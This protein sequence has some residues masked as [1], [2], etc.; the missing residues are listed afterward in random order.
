MSVTD[1]L[2][3]VEAV[4]SGRPVYVESAARRDERFPELGPLGAVA[5]ASL[6][7][8]VDGNVVGGLGLSFD[9]VQP[10]SPAD[11]VALERVAASC[12]RTIDRL[13]V[14]AV[15]SHAGELLANLVDVSSIG[16]I[17]G[18]DDRILEAND[19]FLAMLGYRHTDLEAGE[20][21]WPE[22]TPDEWNSVDDEIVDQ[23]MS[24][25]TSR[26]DGQGVR[27]PPRPPGPGAG[28][29]Q[30]GRGRALPLDRPGRRPHRAEAG[31][32]ADQPGDEGAGRGPGRCR[33]GAGAGLDDPRARSRPTARPGRELAVDLRDRREH[34]VP[35]DV[36]DPRRRALRPAPDERRVAGVPPPRRPPDPHPPAPRRG[37]AGRADVL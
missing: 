11:R 2:P 33:R 12:A 18:E 37:R 9:A 7:L 1:R 17:H 23:M 10:F 27:P 36:P 14:D 5:S 15:G 13:R 20:L 25:G 19:A 30:P 22:L 3:I 4:R 32:A 29:G 31:R 35:R 28:G 24:T 8:I 16:V 21:R 26:A 34:L 6:P